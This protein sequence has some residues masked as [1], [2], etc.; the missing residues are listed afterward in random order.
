MLHGGVLQK[1]VLMPV[2]FICNY[3]NRV[4]WHFFWF[5]KKEKDNENGNSNYQAIQA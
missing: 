2:N 3:A 1:V 4:N 5:N